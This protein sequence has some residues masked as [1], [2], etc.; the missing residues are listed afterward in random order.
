VVE[1][2]EAQTDIN[3]EEG[4]NQEWRESFAAEVEAERSPEDGY[5]EI[6][7]TTVTLYSH[8]ERRGKAYDAPY[9]ARVQVYE[10]K[11]SYDL[12]RTSSK[13]YI[14]TAR[15]NYNEN[16]GMK[17]LFKA[18]KTEK[19]K[20]SLKTYVSA[21]ERNYKGEFVYG[22]EAKKLIKEVEDAMIRKMKA[23]WN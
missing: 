5:Y 18:P 8:W 20:A 4:V 19:E 16:S 7:G 12:V 11:D 1:S 23:I 13:L 3:I 21:V 14:E 6:N 10:L 15:P 9:G 17:Y 2:A 22:D